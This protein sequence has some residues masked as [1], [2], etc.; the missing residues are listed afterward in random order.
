MTY[1]QARERPPAVIPAT[2]KPSPP[3]GGVR[4]TMRPLRVV[5]LNG[6]EEK[7]DGDLCIARLLANTALQLELTI[8]RD[9]H[10]SERDISPHLLHFYRTFTELQ[11]RTYDALVVVGPGLEA[12]RRSGQGSEGELEAVLDWSFRQGHAGLFLGGAA[13]AALALRH[14]IGAR[15]LPARRS[16]VVSHRMVAPD[17]PLLRGHD[18]VVWVP[19]ADGR[20]LDGG[21]LPPG[22]ALASLVES[23]DAGIHILRNAARRQTYVLNDISADAD[24]EAIAQRWGAPSSAGVPCPGASASRIQRGWRA[25]AQLLFANW[26][27]VEVGQD[28]PATTPPHGREGELRLQGAA[29]PG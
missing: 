24:A 5:L 20:G 10:A 15:R 26:L 11:A 13:F 16:G 25:H 23:E 27:A 19:V 22:G 14:G 21:D 17:E 4:R 6:A 1:S 7:C 28:P 2:H 8:L 12:A 3:S 18:R 9:Q 29:V